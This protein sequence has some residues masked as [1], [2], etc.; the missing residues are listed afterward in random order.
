MQAQY[1]ITAPKGL[2]SFSEMQNLE[3][4]KNILPTIDLWTM[5]FKIVT[6]TL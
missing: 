5:H 2:K 1:S 3:L 6:L 4:K